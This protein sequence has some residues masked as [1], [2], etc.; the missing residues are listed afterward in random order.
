MENE[1]LQLDREAKEDNRKV[2]AFLLNYA[3]LKVEYERDKQ[4]YELAREEI[5]HGSSN[6]EE[7]TSMVSGAISDTTGRK[8]IRLADLCDY[9]DVYRWLKLCQEIEQR[10]PWKLK[11]ILQLRRETVT[12]QGYIRAGRYKGRPAWV[13]YVQHKYCEAVAERLRKRPEDV[14]IE[15]Y[16]TFSE[17]WNRIVEYGVRLAAKRGLL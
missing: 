10:L 4:E 11:L 1:I 17:W 12:K 3:Y 15:S 8:G 14:W 13:P 16:Q 2:S 7:R 5:L 9:S 6:P